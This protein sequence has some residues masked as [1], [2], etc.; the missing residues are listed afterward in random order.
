[1]DESLQVGPGTDGPKLVRSFHIRNVY[2]P[3]LCILLILESVSN[4]IKVHDS[5][6]RNVRGTDKRRADN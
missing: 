5:A 1:M 4:K 3:R 6:M 2:R